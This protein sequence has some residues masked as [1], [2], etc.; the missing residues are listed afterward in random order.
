MKNCKK[1]FT[2]RSLSWAVNAAL[3]TMAQISNAQAAD[4]ASNPEVVELTQYSSSV[5]VGV[6]NVGSSSFKAGE[7]NALQKEGAYGVGNVDLR[8]GGSYD[9]EDATRW[10]IQ[11]N[12]LGLDSRD[13]SVEYGQQGS[14]R[15]HLNYDEI[16][17]NRSDSYQTPYLGAGSKTL[18]LPGNWVV[19]VVP[20]NAGTPNARGLS[21]DVAAAPARLSGVLTL[22][23]PAQQATSSALIAADA[24]A[25]HK[26]ELATQRKRTEVGFNVFVDPR[27]ELKTN[28]RHEDKNGLKPM[29]APSRQFA[30]DITAVIPDLIDQ[31]TEQL[32][33][34]MHYTGEH[35][36]LQMGYS[37]S[38]YSNHVDGM[39]W[40]NWATLTPPNIN[41]ISSAPSNDFHQL[42]LTGGYDFSRSTRLVVD[43]ALGRSSQNEHLLSD[44]TTPVVPVSTANAVVDSKT[45]SLK[46]TGH[47]TSDLQLAAVYKYDAREN[48]TPVNTFQFSDNNIALP[49]PS[50]L[51][52][53]KLFAQN[54]NANTPYSKRVN[55]IGLDA[56]Y[57]L[58]KGQS[59]KAGYEYQGT[60]RWCEGSWISC[61]EAANTEDNI[62][63]LEYRNSVF[64][65]ISGRIGY[66]HG[67]RSVRN[68]NENAFLAL[69]PFANVSPV[70][71]TGGATAYSTMLANGLNGWGPNAGFLPVSTNANVAFFFPSNNALLNTYYGN[72]NRISELPGLRE[73]NM[74]DR[75]QDKFKAAINWQASEEWSAQAGV[76]AHKD[77]Y[78]NSVYGLKEA[79]GWS[80]NL[81]AN[82]Q[83]SEDLSVSA[84]YTL[85]D[86]HAKSA[87]NT[88]TANNAANTVATN[89]VNG[90]TTIAGGCYPTIANRNLNNKIDPCNNWS[91]DLHDQIDTMPT[92][93]VQLFKLS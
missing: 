27:W 29:G 15:L 4:A 59:V 67:S 34:A 48:H 3:L 80:L 44:A 77:D 82:Y 73:Y 31:S 14:F 39:T 17:R 90:F 79:S 68:Y 11:A 25:F 62:L 52:P 81:D 8:G 22:P 53:G 20:Q 32:D 76:K 51:F 66:E 54:A 28:F 41:T 55:K 49:A 24:P 60:D 87:G 2:L 19:P 61:V 46:L 50:I 47:A 36:F 83:A 57:R 93:M 86:Q 45:L 56:D 42:N 33:V 78:A 12:D 16:R 10:R 38:F 74:A 43:A 70:G 89:S 58:G 63:R 13:L 64:E 6:G 5:E 23:T 88:Y 72:N 26:V 30:G 35:S 9:S 71:A 92:S 75:N 91:A 21:P 7:Y 69:V 85:E 1:A 40:K 18:S 37:G 84:F 65:N